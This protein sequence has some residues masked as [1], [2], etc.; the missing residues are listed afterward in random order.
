[1][2]NPFTKVTL[3]PSG[4]VTVTLLDPTKAVG[5]IVRFAVSCELELKTQLLTVIPSPKVQVGV[6]KKLEP[7]R[8]TTKPLAPCAPLFG[9]RDAS[10]GGLAGTP[11]VTLNPLFKVANCPFGLLT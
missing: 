4:F 10:V 3:W 5:V 7:E 11:W 8:I 2:L 6:C 1:M 9:L